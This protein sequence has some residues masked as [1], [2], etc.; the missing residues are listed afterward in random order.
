MNSRRID[1]NPFIHLSVH[2]PI[3][4]HPSSIVHRHAPLMM[5]FADVSK[6]TQLVVTDRKL[7]RKWLL[8]EHTLYRRAKLVLSHN[9]DMVM[10]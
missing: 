10:R 7:W 1:V 8:R 9:D 6:L 4:H 5:T 2:P 3:I